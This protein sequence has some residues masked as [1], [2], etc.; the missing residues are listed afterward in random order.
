MRSNGLLIK[1]APA[2]LRVL[3]NVFRVRRHNWDQF[4]KELVGSS[5]SSAMR[6]PFF[7]L[8]LI[9]ILWVPISE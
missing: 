7:T 5:K 6:I 2:L 9:H 8:V 1:L 4:N 3:D